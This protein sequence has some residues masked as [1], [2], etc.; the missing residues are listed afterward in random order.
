[1]LEVDWLRIS[2]EVKAKIYGKDGHAVEKPV[3]KGQS[4][5]REDSDP[6][7]IL[8]QYRSGEEIC[9]QEDTAWGRPEAE[10]EEEE[11]A[12]LDASDNF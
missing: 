4:Q 12:S 9:H 10:A 1:M 6:G 5:A 2:K 8:P 11:E 7:W 3:S